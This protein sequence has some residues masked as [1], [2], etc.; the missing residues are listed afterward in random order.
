MHVVAFEQ[1]QRL[2][3]TLKEKSLQSKK[4][5]QKTVS[6]Q[7]THMGQNGK[8]LPLHLT[9]KQLYKTD[10]KHSCTTSFIPQSVP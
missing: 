4:I 9:A 8:E 3:T 7:C 6:L 10:S 2:N 1:K 5:R